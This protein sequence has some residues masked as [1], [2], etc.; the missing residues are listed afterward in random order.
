VCKKGGVAGAGTLRTGRIDWEGKPDFKKFRKKNDPHRRPAV[1]LVMNQGNDYGVGSAYWKDDPDL[2]RADE[3]LGHPQA[4]SKAR[5]LQLANE[6][7]SDDE[8]QFPA[9]PT[10]S[11]TTKRKI[12]GSRQEISEPLFFSSEDEDVGVTK[13]GEGDDRDEGT[14]TLRSAGSSRKPRVKQGQTRRALVVDDDDSDDG[15]TFKGFGTKPR[16]RGRR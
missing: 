8:D 10:S 12:Q 11:W 16:P 3:F 7:D 9:K 2:A 5:G 14:E 13:H 6:D 4:T 1:E 15:T